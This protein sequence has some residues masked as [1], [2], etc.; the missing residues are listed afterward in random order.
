MTLLGLLILLS[1]LFVGWN[2]GANDAANAMGTAV[3]ARVR[4]I[5]EAVII[6]AVFSFLGAVT[7]GHRVIKTI[8]SGIVPLDQLETGQ[9]TLI[10]LASMLS[11]GSGSCGPPTSSCRCRPPIRRS[12]P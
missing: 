9:A 10:A 11:A 8:G 1:G 4:T 5:R 3:G 7:F 2:L 6:V 12:G